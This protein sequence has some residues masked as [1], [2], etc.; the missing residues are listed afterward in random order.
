[1]CIILIN[2]DTHLD[3]RL[4]LAANRDEFYN[5]PS[6]QASYWDES[7]HIFS[8]RDLLGKGTW[9]GISETGR[10]ACVTNF[11]EPHSI[12]EGLPSRGS[13]VSRFLLEQMSTDDYLK[14]LRETGKD[15]SGFNLIFGTAERLLYF[16]NRCDSHLQIYPGVHGLSNHLL[17]TPWPKVKK[18]KDALC[19]M[20]GL[21][22][23]KLVEALFS[24]LADRTPYHDS[25]LPDT[26]VGV[27]M[28]RILSPVFISTPVYGTRSS[29][30][31][32]IDRNN[33][34]TFIEKTFDGNPDMPRTVNCN[35]K[36]RV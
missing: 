14:L 26:G 20:N 15:Y 24:T 6:R 12:R 28:E 32:L 4:I 23:D 19:R 22:K 3:Y 11:R 5:R 13:L 30:I 8:G 33:E 31:I 35:F 25:V 16:S 7:P 1:M 10:I 36:I 18:G 21:S 2:Y 34:V 29:T 9:L 17:D 27:E